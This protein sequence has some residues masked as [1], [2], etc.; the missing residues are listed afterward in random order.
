MARVLGMERT[1]TRAKV[2]AL[3]AER[4]LSLRLSW[5]TEHGIDKRNFAPL[6]KKPKKWRFANGY[7]GGLL[8]RDQAT[9]AREP[10]LWANVNGEAGSSR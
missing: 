4:I 8:E 2:Y 5:A 10:P 7:C 3:W 1:G 9:L 6:R